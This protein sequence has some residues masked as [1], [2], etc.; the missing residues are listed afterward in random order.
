MENSKKEVPKDKSSVPR[1]RDVFSDSISF[2]QFGSRFSNSSSGKMMLRFK[3]NGRKSKSDNTGKSQI[4][5]NINNK[6]ICVNLKEDANFFR[7]IK[8]TDYYANL[9]K[10]IF[11]I[12]KRLTL[13]TPKDKIKIDKNFDVVSLHFKE[14]SDYNIVEDFNSYQKTKL[15]SLHV[16][17]GTTNDLLRKQK[18]LT[19]LEKKNLKSVTNNENN[20]IITSNENLIVDY[21]KSKCTSF[22][23]HKE[24]Y[25][26][27]NQGPLLNNTS[28]E[29]NLKPHS[30]VNSKFEGRLLLPIGYTICELCDLLV[31]RKLLITMIPC[32]HCFCTRCGK[33]YYEDKIESENEIE[34]TCPYYSCKTVVS[35]DILAKLV[36]VNLLN[37]YNRLINK[38][39]NNNENL[40]LNTNLNP[41]PNFLS[42]NNNTKTMKNE[43]STY[44]STIQDYNKKH[45]LELSDNDNSYYLYQKYK[46]H[47]CQICNLPS[48]FGKNCKNTLKC[49]NCFKKFC[50]FCLQLIDS[51]DHFNTFNEKNCCKSYLKFYREQLRPRKRITKLDNFLRY[52]FFFIISYIFILCLGT[53]YS[54]MFLSKIFKRRKK[55]SATNENNTTI[56]K[57]NRYTNVI[58]IKQFKVLTLKRDFNLRE[59]YSILIYFFLRIIKFLL[60][61][62]FS[63]IYGSFCLIILPYFPL[64]SCLLL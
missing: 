4:Y 45:V 5:I 9:K 54:N 1:K 33:N 51:P 22:L 16:K 6:K 41:S 63:I 39:L 44:F 28:K 23:V 60:V 48:L 27:P 8:S 10:K 15:S 47:F 53:F 35:L 40:N 7:S 17:S 34:L 64:V 21:E 14:D 30:L 32:E 26:S 38:S 2:S 61:I 25:T 37:R 12:E 29:Y 19:L 18:V 20:P 46:G 57:K 11:N 31:P 3:K 56:K 36:S 24:N 43:L 52:F 55:N 59:K 42:L 13:S 62:I 50:K 58:T 49:L